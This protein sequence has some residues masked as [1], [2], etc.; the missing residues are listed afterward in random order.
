MRVGREE[1]LDE[2]AVLVGRRLRELGALG[3]LAAALLEAVLGDRGALDE[4][5]VRDGDHA[6]FVGHDVFHREVAFLGGDLRLAGTDVLLG[7]VAQL[8]LDEGEQLRLAREDA[9]ELFDERHQFA[10]FGLDLVALQAGEL[11]EAEVEDGHGL[12]F[13]E[14]VF[15]H[16]LHAGLVAVGRGADDLH[17]VVQVA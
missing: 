16:E 15:G 17:E 12:P 13:A 5:G 6:A 1:V 3:T 10:V 7:G 14:A 9:A 4:A 11:V 2:V 8:L